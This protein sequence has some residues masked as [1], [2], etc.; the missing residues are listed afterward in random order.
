M[1]SQFRAAVKVQPAPARPEVKR[2]ALVSDAT[3]AGAETLLETV[4]GLLPHLAGAEWVSL[5]G[6]EARSVGHMIERVEQVAPQL[7]IAPRHLFEDE[8]DLP[9]SLGTHA[10]MLTQ[11]ISPPVLLLPHPRSP[12]FPKAADPIQSAL[13]ITDHIVGDDRLVGWGLF[14]VEGGGRLVLAH[15]EDDLVLERY[16]EAISKIPGLDTEIAKAGLEKRLLSDARDY[17]KRLETGLAKTHPSVKVEPVVE[18]G[19]SVIDHVRIVREERVD[20]VVMNTKD[21]AQQA[22]HGLAYSLSV[23]LVDVPLLLL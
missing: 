14:A 4:R 15:I 17:L 2:I 7:V 13:V 16:L 19:H 9:H 18:R 11:S 21:D 23:E 1:E 22:M 12:S 5:G 3:E 8:V 20:L 6:E 10:D